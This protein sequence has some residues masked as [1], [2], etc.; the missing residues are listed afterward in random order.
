M[1]KIK[2]IM[3]PNTPHAVFT[4][5]N[6]ICH[7]GHFYATSTMQD[8]MFGIV[9]TFIAN[10]VLTNAHKVTH[11]LIL[12]RIAVFYHSI[13]VGRKIQDD[14]ASCTDGYAPLPYRYLFY[15]IRV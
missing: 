1:Y 12:R 9:H 3:R 2:R 7:G 15:F 14:G 11:G 8:T 13:L 4:P 6:A 10:A 5:E